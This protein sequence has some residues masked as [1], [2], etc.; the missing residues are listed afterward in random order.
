MA[1][2][3]QP[4]SRIVQNLIG[5]HIRPTFI[6]DVAECVK[7]GQSQSVLENREQSAKRHLLT[8]PLPR[9]CNWTRPIIIGTAWITIWDLGYNVFGTN[10]YTNAF[11]PEK[12]HYL[13]SRRIYDCGSTIVCGDGRCF[14]HVHS[15]LSPHCW[16]Q[17]YILDIQIFNDGDKTE[18]I[19]DLSSNRWA[20]SFTVEQDGQQSTL[21]TT[22][23]PSAQKDMVKLQPRGLQELRFEV[24]NAAAWT[25]G[26]VKLSIQAPSLS[27]TLSARYRHLPASD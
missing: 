19:Q 25:T 18:E 23:E 15:S 12:M 1:Y 14:R 5:E 16:Y 17:P 27:R 6:Y 21:K 13:G 4:S 2:A 22:K 10:S 20:V 11:T 9:I 3:L 26:T 8:N 24:P 7:L